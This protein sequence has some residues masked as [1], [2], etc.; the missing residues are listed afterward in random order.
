MSEP[1]AAA[2]AEFLRGL[3]DV[4][5]ANIASPN[6]LLSGQDRADAPA[7]LRR[8]AHHLDRIA[9]G[10]DRLAPKGLTAQPMPYDPEPPSS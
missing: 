10:G 2:D 4:L 6:A 1:D 8:I 3:A 7:R 5:E 9:T